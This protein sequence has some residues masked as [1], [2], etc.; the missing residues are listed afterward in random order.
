METLSTFSFLIYV[1]LIALTEVWMLWLVYKDTNKAYFLAISPLRWLAIII[2]VSKYHQLDLGFLF[3]FLFIATIYWLFLPLLVNVIV[4]KKPVFYVGT[5]GKIG[6]MLNSLF[7]QHVA[8][9]TFLIKLSALAGATY[10][11]WNYITQH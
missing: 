5:D 4:I 9:F 8:I 3:M 10:L 11:Y 6:A 1:V 7:G 2:L